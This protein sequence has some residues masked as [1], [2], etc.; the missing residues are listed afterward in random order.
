MGVGRGGRL[1]GGGEGGRLDGGGEGGRLDGGGEGGRL[2]GGGEGVRLD[3]VTSTEICLRKVIKNDI[4][5]ELANAII[6][7][8]Y[9]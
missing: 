5:I 9:C 7:F 3:G 1:D 4:N 6:H 2:D 8:N